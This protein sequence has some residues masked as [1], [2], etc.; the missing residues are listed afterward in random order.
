MTAPTQISLRPRLYQFPIGDSVITNVLEGFIQ[1]HDMHPFVATNATAADVAELAR[2]YRLPFPAIEHNFVSTVV[3]TRDKLIVIDPGFGSAAPAPN[4]GWFMEGLEGA[5]YG[6]HDVDIVL[7]SHCHPDHIGNVAKDGVPTFPNA[8]IVLGRTEFDFWNAGKGVS[9]MR[10]PTLELFQKTLVPL[11]DQLRLIE[12]GDEIV[13]GL[14]AID[15][16]GH[17]AGHLVFHLTTGDGELLMLNDTTAHYA[18]SF[19]HPEWHFAMDDNPEHAAV[20]RR[21]ILQFA[22]DR[23]IPVVG[24]HLPFPAIGFV[25]QR[26]EGFEF[27]PAT[28]QFNLNAGG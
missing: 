19:A 21:R 17:S 26:D 18:G 15:A 5:G 10:R 14:T 16:F 4:T 25:E 13:A 20:S 2:M 22:A 6:A 7:I 11:K 12:P 1:R 3:K 24:F 28:Y 9:E 8:E 23:T 27:R